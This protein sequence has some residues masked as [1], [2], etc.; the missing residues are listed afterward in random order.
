MGLD[1][2][3]GGDFDLVEVEFLNVLGQQWLS[4]LQSIGKPF[5]FPIDWRT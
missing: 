5:W 1:E 4:V 2:S 3:K